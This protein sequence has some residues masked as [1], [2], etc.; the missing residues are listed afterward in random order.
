MKKLFKYSLLVATA[1]SVTACADISMSTRERVAKRITMPVGLVKR[2]IPAAP[3]ALTAYE[4]VYERGGVANVYIEGDG[5]AWLS[6][7]TKSLN[8]TPKNPVALHLASRDRA[9]NVIWL[10]RPCQYS[11]MLTPDTICSDEYWGQ[12]RYAPEVIDA[13]SR[14]LDELKARYGFTG[15]NLIG[16]SG[17]AAVASLVP[18]KRDD[19]LSIR[20]VAGNLDHK[21]HS[22]FHNVSILKGS[23]NPP[24]YASTLSKI[25]QMHF[26]GGQDEVV[27][28]TILHSY[29]QS[30]GNLNCVQ[31][32]FIQQA[33]HDTGWVDIW[34]ELLKKTPECRTSFEVDDLPPLGDF[35]ADFPEPIYAAPLD[36][37]KP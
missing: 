18:T 5:Q 30:I 23:L 28:S 27:P 3:F 13:Y 11:G 2:E 33:D 10:A 17:G 22:K 19:I 9:Q 12:K 16:F 20:S 24:D 32:D 36:P 6:R 25:P 37:S 4:R 8:P 35:S 14:A 21:A 29:L 34:P 1:I 26:V 7:S 31:Y 15:F